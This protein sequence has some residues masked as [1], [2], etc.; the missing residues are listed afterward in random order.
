MAWH[1]FGAVA[2]FIW[3]SLPTEAQRCHSMPAFK[4]VL[5]SRPSG[6][7]WRK[8]AWLVGRGAHS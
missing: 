4:S 5:L 2:A 3:Y 1:A 6:C 7:R 8:W